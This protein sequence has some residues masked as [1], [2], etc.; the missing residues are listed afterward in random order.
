MLR[1]RDNQNIYRQ[2]VTW[3]NQR[4]VYVRSDAPHYTLHTCYRHVAC[5]PHNLLR[6]VQ[7]IPY[8][9]CFVCFR[10][11]QWWHTRQRGVV[12]PPSL[13]PVVLL[14]SSTAA[15]VELLMVRHQDFCFGK[16]VKHVAVRN[17][18]SVYLWQDGDAVQLPLNTYQ[19][20]SSLLS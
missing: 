20:A 18:L 1:S 6:S 19:E 7:Q 5:S 2:T 11:R 8:G 9:C 3:P 4:G 17:V 14:T 15:V 10:Q 16:E 12:L 13:R